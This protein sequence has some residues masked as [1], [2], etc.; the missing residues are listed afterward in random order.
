MGTGIFRML[1]TFFHMVIP[2]FQGTFDPF[3]GLYSD[4]HAACQGKI[5]YH[6]LVKCLA[7]PE[8]ILFSIGN[9]TN[10]ITWAFNKSKQL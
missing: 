5:K 10:C 3:I 2:S 4:Q 7:I 1:S 6:V 9:I 8:Q